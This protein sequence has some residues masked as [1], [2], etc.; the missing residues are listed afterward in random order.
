MSYCHAE[1]GIGPFVGGHPCESFCQWPLLDDMQLLS[2]SCIAWSSTHKQPE[3][4]LRVEAKKGTCRRALTMQADLC[5][6]S[7]RAKEI[8]NEE[9]SQEDDTPPPRGGEPP[10]R[11]SPMR[12]EA[13]LVKKDNTYHPRG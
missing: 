3:R 8:A 2:G 13:Y 1:Q 9:P 4:T 10:T 12:S 5:K 7:L 11:R 6:S